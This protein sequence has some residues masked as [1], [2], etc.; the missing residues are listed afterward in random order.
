MAFSRS[1]SSLSKDIV[2]PAMGV[3]D[4]T[5]L[6]FV[7]PHGYMKGREKFGFR[8]WRN[9][10]VA[11]AGLGALAC[12]RTDK[13]ADR[14][15]RNRAVVYWAYIARPPGRVKEYIPRM[16]PPRWTLNT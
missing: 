5:H 15:H 7:L 2:G 14:P 6:R 11:R 12:R 3:S 10:D 13:P 1:E 8:V 9:P 4:L 16:S